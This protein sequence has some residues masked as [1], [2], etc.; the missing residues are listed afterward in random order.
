MNFK[1][2]TENLPNKQYSYMFIKEEE[3]KEIS[4]NFRKYRE[5]CSNF[6]DAINEQFK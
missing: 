4:V 5:I 3:A 2:T 1:N 6:E